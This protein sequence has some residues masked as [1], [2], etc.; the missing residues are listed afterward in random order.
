[1]L[2]IP[3]GTRHE[4]GVRARDVD[5]AQDE[6]PAILGVP[7]RFFRQRLEESRS[8]AERPQ[9]VGPFAAVSLQKAEFY[10]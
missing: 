9:G 4:L 6:V 10:Q 5:E 2:L 7:G 1:M 8:L 3:A